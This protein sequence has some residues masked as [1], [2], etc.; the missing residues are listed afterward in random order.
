[1]KEADLPEQVQQLL[2]TFRMASDVGG[3]IAKV[4]A[5]ISVPITIYF[6]IQYLSAVSAPFPIGMSS[7]PTLLGVLA[8]AFCI[9]FV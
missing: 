8:T 6:I 1:M 9:V 7:S 3:E 4:A 5:Y 2:A